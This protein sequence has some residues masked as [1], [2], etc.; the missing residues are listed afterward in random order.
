MA[1]GVSIAKNNS[2]NKITIIDDRNHTR[3][4]CHHS[5]AYTTAVA[6]P[7]IFIRAAVSVAIDNIKTVSAA[8]T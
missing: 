5:F 6:S 7:A 2:I 8:I 3:S 4:H 1:A